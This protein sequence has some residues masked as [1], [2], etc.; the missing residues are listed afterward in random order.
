MTDEIF[1][2][3]LLRNLRLNDFF[4]GAQELM[5]KNLRPVIDVYFSCVTYNTDYI[6]L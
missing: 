4:R 3:A 6:I 1:H 5:E 2:S